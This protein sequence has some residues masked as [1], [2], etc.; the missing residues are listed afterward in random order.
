[1]LNTVTLAGTEERPAFETAYVP[2]LFIIVAAKRT[3]EALLTA[4]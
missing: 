2:S 3:P 1:L 4:A